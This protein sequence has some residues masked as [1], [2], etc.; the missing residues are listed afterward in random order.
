M[1]IRYDSIAALRA[2][3]LALNCDPYEASNPGNDAWYNNETP[4]DTLRMAISGDTRLVAKAEEAISKLDAIIE[5]PRLVWEPNVAGA[6]CCVPDVLAGRP[7]NMRRMVHRPDER[8]PITIIANTASSAGLDTQ[9]LAKRGTV[10]LAFVLALSRIRP[11]TLHQM[12]T[13]NG[14]DGETVVISQIST[15][16]LDLATA[17]YA[18]TSC[19]FTRRIC[20][21]VKTK[22]H[23][24]YTHHWPTGY[25]PTNPINYNNALT[26]RLGLNPAQS[27]I[28]AGA[29]LHDDL[30]VRPIKWITQQIKRFTQQ[31]EEGAD[32]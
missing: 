23:N 10:I 30:I 13:G 8:A 22:K 15:T 21:A 12:S 7:T 6:F 3:Y 26:L 4:Q 27:L 16:P 24:G 25:N 20:Y 17:C 1:I 14:N 11:V 32:T 18:L 9:T 28:I 2:D 5:T 19:G 31:A 29:H